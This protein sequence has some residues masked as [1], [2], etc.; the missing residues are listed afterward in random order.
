MVKVFILNMKILITEN[1]N[2]RLNLYRRIG[3]IK[4]IINDF[5]DVFIRTAKTLNKDGFIHATAMFIGDIIA[6]R[7]DEKAVDFD[8]VTFRNQIKVFV[9]S[10]FYE[11]LIDFYN[12]HKKPLTESKE[13]EFYY[14]IPLSVK[15]RMTD[16]D[17]QVLDSIIDTNKRW[18]V[19]FDF[20]DYLDRNLHDSLNEFIHDYKAEEIDPNLD[21]DDWD[22]EE[23]RVYEIFRQLMPFLKKK[24]YDE[25]SDYYVEKRRRRG[26]MNESE[27]NDIAYLRRKEIIK[28]L[29]DNRIEVIRDNDNVCNYAF[30]EFLTEVS[31]QVSDNSHKLGI[32][33]N[34]TNIPLIHKWVRRNFSQY[35]EDKYL[36]LIDSEG[37]NDEDDDDDDDY[38]SGFL[39][40]VDNNQ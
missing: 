1:Q 25:L 19:E 22:R 34:N 40:G 33:S 20:D 29:I 23:S 3:E 8:Y 5:E 26:V 10:H 16:R 11:E 9:Q 38:L 12:K 2:E 21:N 17:F 15:R 24:Y 18:G 32:E 36:E 31:W 4:D 27:S 37:C 39:Y 13:D 6:G 30:S 35:I 28:D 7:L 14:L